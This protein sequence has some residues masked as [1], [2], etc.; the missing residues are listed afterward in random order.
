MSVARFWHRSL[1]DELIGR[2]RTGYPATA[3]L[4][5]C[6][7]SF[8]QEG[9]IPGTY[10]IHP[11]MRASL[12][13]YQDSELRAQVH[14][15]LFDRYTAALRG[16]DNSTIDESEKTAFAEAFYHGKHALPADEF[17]GWFTMTADVF[18]RAGMWRFLIPLHEEF[19]QIVEGH[20]GPDHP[21]TATSLDNLATLYNHQ[22]QYSE[23][24][25]LY[26]RALM[27]RE[28]NLGPEHPDTTETLVN[29]GTLYL[30]EGRYGEADTYLNEALALT[31]KISGH[32]HPDVARILY[33]LATLRLAEGQYGEADTFANEALTLWKRVS[34]SEHPY[35]ASSLYLLGSVYRN[36]GRYEEAEQVLHRALEI[37][38]NHFRTEHPRTMRNLT[39]LAILYGDMGRYE[40]AKPMLERALKTQER[41]LSTKAPGHCCQSIP[42]REAPLSARTLRGEPTVVQARTG[43]SGRS[44]GLRASR[45]DSNATS[46][47]EPDKEQGDGSYVAAPTATQGLRVPVTGCRP[48][49]RRCQQRWHQR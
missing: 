42:I 18:N 21:D 11:L 5:L 8:V 12:Q 25:M 22:G 47:G 4:E 1:F 33:F 38:E 41:I 34:G 31:K 15:H 32:E 35:L 19:V 6:R 16:L 23:A 14:R 40:E 26:Q 29:L 49:P 13:E 37:S 28:K 30:D 46:V 10:T 7:F 3:F 2:F 45:Y 24:E 39:E 17:S 20:L 48:N 27:I 36:Q 44:I 9:Q 43:N